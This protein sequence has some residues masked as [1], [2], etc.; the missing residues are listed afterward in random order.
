MVA[1][2][3]L[4]FASFLGFLAACGRPDLDVSQP[5]IVGGRPVVE[6]EALAK[7][8][9][10]FI[11]HAGDIGCSG[12]IIS[13]RHIL[14]AG[15]CFGDSVWE[16][17]HALFA[18]SA[19]DARFDGAKTNVRKVLRAQHHEGYQ[20]EFHSPRMPPFDI[21]IVTLTSDIPSGYVP[22]QIAPD[23]MEIKKGDVV[24]L[25]GFGKT[26]E[27]KSDVGILRTVDT[28]V[29]KLRRTAKEVEFGPN[30]GHGA[31]GGDSGGPAFVERNGKLYLLAL[32]SRGLTDNCADGHVVYTDVRYFKDWIES[33]EHAEFFASNDE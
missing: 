19:D 24:T 28:F 10:L 21:S 3:T 30:P 32:T 12:V 7:S 23:S 4:I 31:C 1:G 29:N 27:D 6:G 2:K 26:A 33:H 13:K 8:A 18:V 14:S 11:D 25:V 22:A 9:V 16:D 5:E 17:A 15:H 20:G